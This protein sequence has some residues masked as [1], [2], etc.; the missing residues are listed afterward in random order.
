MGI[1]ADHWCHGHYMGHDV[2]RYLL[3]LLQVKVTL[4]G[5]CRATETS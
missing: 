1:N 3:G 4:E 5:I 2:R